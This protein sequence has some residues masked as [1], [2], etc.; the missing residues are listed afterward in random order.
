[1]RERH[2]EKYLKR[3]MREIIDET[4]TINSKTIAT[5]EKE[6]FSKLVTI[7]GDIEL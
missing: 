2:T 1:M 4:V 7:Y 6:L 3:E 5:E